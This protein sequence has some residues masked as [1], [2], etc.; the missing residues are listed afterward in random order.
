MLFKD[1]DL[2]IERGQRWGIIGP[3]GAGK[4]T[5]VRCLLGET[6]IDDGKVMPGGKLSI[7][8]YR[9]THEGMDPDLTVVRF[10]QDAVLKQ[11]EGV[12]LTEQQARDLAG[13]FLFS[14]QAQE[15]QLGMLSG[16]ERGRAMLASLLA[17]GKNVLVLDEPT[18]HFDIPSA[19]RLEETLRRPPSPDELALDENAGRE[20]G[21]FDGTL[22][23]ISHDRALLDACCDR[24][25]VMDGKGGAKVFLGG[26]TRWAESQGKSGDGKAATTSH[27]KTPQKPTPTPVVNA[28]PTGPKPKAEKK[29]KWSWMGV[30]QIESQIASLTK[31]MAKIDAKLADADVWLDLDKANALTDKRDE[32]KAELDG[33]ET[34][35]V[36]KAE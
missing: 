23:L 28:K 30:D 36:K 9:Q 20:A 12:R 5:L 22:I 3:N 15:K 26:Y 32:V 7:G 10:L 33:L 25:L 2:T 31:E 18:N 17:T 8:Y 27:A 11:T 29:S 21:L 16:G 4:T 13:A 34:E 14:G 19:E 1:L 35:W 24:L 6:E